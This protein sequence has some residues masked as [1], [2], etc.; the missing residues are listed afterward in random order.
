MPNNNDKEIN[1]NKFIDI[2]IRILIAICCLILSVI[3]L[4]LSYLRGKYKRYK[5]WKMHHN[6]LSLL[7]YIFLFVKNKKYFN[8]QFDQ[9]V[10]EQSDYSE[11]SDLN[12]D[13][14]EFK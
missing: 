10:Q 7:F 12:L 6:L 2:D 9:L 14:P 3:A 11:F 4:C 8:R 13:E 5:Q 1:N